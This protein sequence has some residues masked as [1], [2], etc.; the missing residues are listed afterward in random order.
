MTLYGQPTR[1]K[2]FKMAIIYVVIK[3][4]I[5]TILEKGHCR[6]LPH[7][8]LWS[9]LLLHKCD[10][11][12]YHMYFDLI[13]LSFIYKKEMLTGH[14]IVLKRNTVWIEIETCKFYYIGLLVT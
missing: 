11:L 4:D 10:Y 8:H 1:K 13:V 6:P 7:H 2:A 3:S 12:F 5:E 14:V 9:L